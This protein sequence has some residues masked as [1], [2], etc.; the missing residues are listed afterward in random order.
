MSIRCELQCATYH[1]FPSATAWGPI[2]PAPDN[3]CPL[4]F[5]TTWVWSTI[6]LF[7]RENLGCSWRR[8]QK[9]LWR[10]DLALWW[11]D[12][13]VDTARVGNVRAFLVDRISINP[14]PPYSS[15][16]A[17]EQYFL[18]LWMKGD[19]AVLQWSLRLFWVILVEMT[20]PQ[21]SRAEVISLKSVIGAIGEKV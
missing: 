9:W 21:Y 3:W 20:L 13:P 15:D 5:L 7:Q 17:P 1:C 18:F 16:G 14:P 12:A 2:L 4:S 8:G 11:D 19:L 6:T 10:S